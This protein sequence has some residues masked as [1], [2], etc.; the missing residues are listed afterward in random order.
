MS[1]KVRFGVFETNSSSTHNLSIVSKEM[2]E[3]FKN[4]ELLIMGEELVTQEE[5]LKEYKENQKR[6]Y[7]SYEEWLENTRDVETYDEWKD[8]ECLET[9]IEEYTSAS[10]D[11]I[12]VFGKYGTDC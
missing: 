4:G 9:F 2:F 6:W 11:E 7:D 3:K 8:D 12:V 5:A 1:K 10:G